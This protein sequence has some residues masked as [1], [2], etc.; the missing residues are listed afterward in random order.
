MVF[1]GNTSLDK[2]YLKKLNSMPAEISCVGLEKFPS[3]EFPVRIAGIG[4]ISFDLAVYIICS[5]RIPGVRI[6]FI[7]HAIGHAVGVDI[8]GAAYIANKITAA[9]KDT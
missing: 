1:A 9:G 2:L 4:I 5:Q 6:P 8:I 3:S 7:H